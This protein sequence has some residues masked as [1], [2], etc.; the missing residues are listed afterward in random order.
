[1]AI[2]SGLAGQVVIAPET[3]YGTYVA[4]TTAVEATSTL[5]DTSTY[6]TSGGVAAGR[7]QRLGS[8]RVKTAL[9]AEGN[10]ALEVTNKGMGKLLRALMG[11]ST[12][13]QQGATPAWLQTHTLGDPFGQS[14][15]VQVGVPDLQGVVQPHTYLGCKVTSA[16]FKC[17]IGEQLTSTF[18]LDA[19]ELSQAQSLVAAS[20]AVSLSPFHWLQSSLKIGTFG[21]EAAA[22]GVRGAS[23]TIGRPSRVDRNYAGNAGRK[24]EPVIND[25][26]PITGSVDVD[27]MTK[28]EFADRFHN[29]TG[30]SMVW[31]FIGPVISGAFFETFRI[32]LPGCFLTG[33]TPQLAGPDIVTGSFPFEWLNDGTNAPKIEYI[34]TDTA[35]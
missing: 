35:F 6:T 30:F 8:R 9:G 14:L 5:R 10:L 23:V 4:P 34:S 13:V 26:Q 29:G 22:N 18:T 16:E 32:T 31:E 33:D 20:Y 15:T 24:S 17:S 25:W 27:Y 11:N 21:A 3:T 28:A 2:R 1:M 7:M 19:R 12:I